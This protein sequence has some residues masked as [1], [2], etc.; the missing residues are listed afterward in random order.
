MDVQHRE[1]SKHNEYTYSWIFIQEI[2]LI[3]CLVI[4]K[5]S[6]DCLAVAC[7]YINIL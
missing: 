2:Y 5:D 3:T 7:R 4:C 6:S 1:H